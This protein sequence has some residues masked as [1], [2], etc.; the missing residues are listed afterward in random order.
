[1]AKTTPQKKEIILDAVGV[2]KVYSVSRP[3]RTVLASVSLTIHR[4]EFIALMGPSGSGKTTLLNVLSGLTPPDTGTV[5]MTGRDLYAMGDTERTNFRTTHSGTVFQSY[6]LVPTLTA[7]ENIALPLALKN[8]RSWSPFGRSSDLAAFREAGAVMEQLGLKG[9]QGHTPDDISGGEKQ[10]VAIARALVTHPAILFADEPTGNLDWVS[11]R[12]V[13]SLFGDLHTSSGQTVVLVTH[14]AA[15][16]A[17][18]DR[19][20]IMRDGRIVHELDLPRSGSVDNA[21][22]FLLEKLATLGL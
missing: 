11:S 17:Y 2:S 8:D 6:N 16:A 22:R 10:K 9:M 15:A 14:E 12:D 20:C 7:A 1:M 19:V 4:G 3:P 18:A 21:R 13:M 5:T